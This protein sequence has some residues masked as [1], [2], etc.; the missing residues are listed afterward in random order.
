LEE[1]R[2]YQTNQSIKELSYE[3]NMKEVK[4]ANEICAKMGMKIRF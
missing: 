1:K 3:K 4:E 2:K